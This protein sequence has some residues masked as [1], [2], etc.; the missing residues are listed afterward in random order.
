[1]PPTYSHN[2]T[3]KATTTP[4]YKY[5]HST[6]TVKWATVIQ[7]APATAQVFPLAA[8][9]LFAEKPHQGHHDPIS[10]FRL[11]A[12][13]AISNTMTAMPL[14]LYDSGTRSCCTGKERDAETGL[15]YF[16][17]RYF[18][19][20]QGRFTSPDPLMASAHASNPQTWNRYAYALNNPL[21]FVDP[22]GME[23][24]PSCANDQN[25]PISVKIN[26]IY[27]KTIHNGNGLTSAE[28]STFEKDQ[29]AKAQKDYSNSNINLQVSYTEGSYTGQDAN[30]K[31]Q[32]TGLQSDALNI[33]V[34][35]ATP[36][37]RNVSNLL[38][39]SATTFINF[40]DVIN[41]N[42]GVTSNSTEH[43]LGHQFL[44]DPFSPGSSNVA[45]KM[46]QNFL[47][48][49]R[50]DT[51][52]TLQQFGQSQAPYRTGLEPRVY[53]VPTNPE[54]NKPQK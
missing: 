49:D 47:K 6:R 5:I 27:D 28:R 37:G 2:S 41:G 9:P 14:W 45:V 50:I 38:D 34:S 30:G 40:N 33:V 35:N 52:N 20:A 36:N 13:L 23:V 19:G 3:P 32:V 1:M 10:T 26:V 25:C 53:A 24:P 22:N 44:G 18:S 11:G 8:L 54:A 46:F 48:D 17:A 31:P 43:E 42:Y 12:T 29:L 16:G 7:A 39:G 21:R 4:K 51:M 15:D